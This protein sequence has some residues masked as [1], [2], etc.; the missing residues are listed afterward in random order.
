MQAMESQAQ[1][2]AGFLKGLAN[3]H[4]LL[5]LC[6]LG[7]DEKSVTQLIEETGIAQTSM[8]QHLAKLRDEGIVSYRRDHRTLYYKVSNPAIRDI[9]EVLYDHFCGKIDND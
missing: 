2:V 1:E 5:I 6:R 3:T 8:S 4:R 9:M 7:A